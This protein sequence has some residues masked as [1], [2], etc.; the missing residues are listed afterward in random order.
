MLTL[1]KTT[2]LPRGWKVKPTRFLYCLYDNTGKP[3]SYGLTAD[4]AKNAI[5]LQPEM[6]AITITTDTAAI[7]HDL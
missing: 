4:I 3:R 7:T 6:G 5:W 2:G 1:C